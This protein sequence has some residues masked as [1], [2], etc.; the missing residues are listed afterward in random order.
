M[1]Q[2]SRFHSLTKDALVCLL[3]TLSPTFHFKYDSGYL[4]INLKESSDQFAIYSVPLVDLK[5]FRRLQG[6]IDVLSGKKIDIPCIL[7][8][9]EIGSFTDYWCEG[10]EWKA[11]VRIYSPDYEVHIFLG[12]IKM[13]DKMELRIEEDW[14][15]DTCEGSDSSSDEDSGGENKV[16]EAHFG[17][18]LPL[19]RCHLPSLIKAL[20]DASEDQRKKYEKV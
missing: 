3:E 8:T 5:E 14:I 16:N 13:K 1:E 15:S 18:S 12:L 11:G 10:E 19:N 20:T 4:F 17:I 9:P 6:L 7:G 2:P